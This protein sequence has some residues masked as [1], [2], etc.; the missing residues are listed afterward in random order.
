MNEHGAAHVRGLLSIGA[1]VH[2]LLLLHGHHHVS[3]TLLLHLVGHM[4]HLLLL[5][6]FGHHLIHHHPLRLW[7]WLLRRSYLGIVAIAIEMGNI[8][9]L[10]VAI[11]M[12]ITTVHYVVSW[13]TIGANFAILLWWANVSVDWLLLLLLL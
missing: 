4:I 10:E 12:I 11:D 9:R 2:Q 5:V 7:W 1:S 3:L 8:V 13:P 6:M